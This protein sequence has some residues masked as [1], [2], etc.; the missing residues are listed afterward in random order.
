VLLVT[1]IIVCHPVRL[2]L[3]KL[4]QL[5]VEPGQVP[6]PRSAAAG[7]QVC[8]CHF[9]CYNGTL[10]VVMPCCAP[11]ALHA[12]PATGGTRTSTSALHFEIVLII[13]SV[14]PSAAAAAA[15]AVQVGD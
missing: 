10:M 9:V 5:L 7:I 12:A 6:R 3:Y 1:S 2:L 13:A 4:P 8:T 11:A 14:M 15:A